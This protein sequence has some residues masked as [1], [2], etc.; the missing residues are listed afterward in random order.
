M[1]R[2]NRFQYSVLVAGMASLHDS[3]K[4]ATQNKSAFVLEQGRAI[5]AQS[6]VAT[7][8]T[9]KVSLKAGEFLHLGRRSACARQ[10]RCRG[11]RDRARR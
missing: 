8:M 5:E 1:N 7:P 11:S 10:Y 3:Q 4:P 6:L 2:H 9:T